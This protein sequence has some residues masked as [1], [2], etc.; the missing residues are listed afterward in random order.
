MSFQSSIESGVGDN[1]SEKRDFT[2]CGNRMPKNQFTYISQVIVIYGIMI[3]AI[4][5]LSLQSPNRELWL[6]LLSSSLGYILP[7][8]GLKFVKP[9]P[10]NPLVQSFD[11]VDGKK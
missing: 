2:C 8:P 7:S 6:V 1:K 11:F 3:T 4:V 5:H 10:S 9:P